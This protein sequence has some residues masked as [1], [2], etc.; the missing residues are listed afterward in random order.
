MQSNW[1]APAERA[2]S[3][4]DTVL[5]VGQAPLPGSLRPYAASPLLSLEIEMDPQ[6]GTAC[7]VL[8][9]ELSP[10]ATVLLEGLFLGKELESCWDTAL[11]S[12]E[13][14][15]FAPNRL[16]LLQAVRAA[17]GQFLRWKQAPSTDESAGAPEPATPVPLTERLSPNGHGAA[18][19]RGTKH[20]LA[21]LLVTLLAHSR[22][23]D[24]HDAAHLAGRP[25]PTEARRQAVQLY[26]VLQQILHSVQAEQ[27]LLE[28]Q[29]VPVAI[30]ALL[31]KALRRCSS[32]G[33][34]VPL[35]QRLPAD[36]DPARGDPLVLEEA[37]AL[38]FD[39][40]AAYA[41]AASAGV[42]IAAERRRAELQ[43]T[44]GLCRRESEG[45]AEAIG[46]AK[47][48]QATDPLEQ[49]W[50]GGLGTLAARTLVEHQ[51]GRLWMQDSF[52]QD[53]HILCLALPAHVIQEEM[54]MR[55]SDWRNDLPITP[56]KTT[57]V[58]AA[59]R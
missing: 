32:L 48:G 31:Q 13:S 17:R 46:K 4:H 1:N 9:H 59:W 29:I 49:M 23:L 50:E 43:L 42:E 41:R 11:S 54:E 34:E 5:L 39:E 19:R 55:P 36:L 56:K 51:G 25:I 58:T 35:E 27:G 24:G 30:P 38:L 18:S 7:N 37:L 8:C 6:S 16:A 20:Q 15:Y 44:I 26:A 3:C 14:R 57:R 52:P 10:S 40:V 12:L 47:S 21:T 2:E 33:R 53:H 22:L 45:L 28:P